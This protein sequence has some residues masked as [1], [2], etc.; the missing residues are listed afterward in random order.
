MSERKKIWNEQQ[1]DLELL[2]L[3]ISEVKGILREVSQQISRIDRRVRVALPPSDNLV[4]KSPPKILET[5]EAHT[6]VTELTKRAR[7]GEQIEHALTRMNVK[8]ELSVLAR[9]LGMTNKKLPP[10]RDLVRRIST[11]IRQRASVETGIHGGAEA[12]TKIPV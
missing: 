3:E 2:A 12:N 1:D 10:K 7:A 9:E 11:R 4:G 8:G 5:K 6:I